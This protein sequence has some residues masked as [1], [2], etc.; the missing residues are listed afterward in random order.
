MNL[1]TTVCGRLRT[2]VRSARR[3]RSASSSFRHLFPSAGRPVGVAATIILTVLLALAAGSNL[4]MAGPQ[5]EAV[6]AL[7][8]PRQ[9]HTAT[10]LADGRVLIV[11]GQDAS[12][13]LASAEVYDP[14]TRSF[15]AAGA[16]STARTG[17]AATLLADGRVLITGGQ[18]NALTLASA[19]IFDVTTPGFQPVAGSM[20]AAR[21]GHT[22]TLLAS[23]QVLLAGGDAAGTAEWFDPANSTFSGSQPMVVRRSGHAAS[24][25]GDRFIFFTRGGTN[26]VELYDADAN[27]FEPWPKLLNEVRVGHTATSNPDDSI[28]LIGGEHV[29]TLERLDVENSVSAPSIALGAAGSVAQRLANDRVLVLGSNLSALFN[30][31][32]SSVAA[33]AGAETLMR[34]GQTTSELPATKH[35]LVAGGVDASDALVP[36][37]AIYTP[38]R[39]ETDKEDYYPDEP[40][41]VTGTGWKAGEE[42]DLYVVD[43]L[44]WVYDSTVVADMDG[45]FVADPYFVVLWQHLGVEFNL[46]ALGADSGLVA[47]HTFT[48]GD[49]TFGASGLPSG[50]SVTVQWSYTGQGNNPPTSSTTTFLAPGPSPA[51]FN[52]QQRTVTYQYPGTVSHNGTDYELI[53]SSPASGFNSGSGSV[54]TA[55]VANYRGVSTVTWNTPSDITYGTPLDGTQ[56]NATANV[57]GTWNYTPAASTVLGAGTHDLSVTFTPTDINFSTI[58]KTVQINVLKAEL[59]VTAND[60]SKT[61]N[62]DAYTGGNGVTYSGFVN[63]ETETVLG[64]S[65]TYGGASQGAIDAGTYAISPSGRSSGNYNISYVDGT[66][67]IDKADATVSVTGTTVTYDGDAHGATGTATGVNG[68]ALAGLDLGGSFA[69]VPGGTANWTFTDITGNYNDTSGSVAIVI[70]KADATIAVQGKTVTYDGQA[71]SATG[72]ATGVQ[73]ET[74]SG[75]DLGASYTN[76]PGGTADWTFTDVTGNYHNASGSVQIVIEK[77]NATITVQGATVT[78][79]GQAHGATGSASGVQGETLAGLNLGASFTNAP[80]GT[81][82]W[83]FTDVTGNYHNAVGSVGIVIQKANA[84]IAVQGTTVTYDGQAHGATGSATGVQGETLA[85]LD[86]GASYTN[87]PGGTANWTFTDVTGNYFDA[88]GSVAI[89]ITKAG[90]S[91]SV[92]GFSGVYDGAAHGATGSAIG[93]NGETLAGLDLGASFTNVPGGTANWTF[94]DVTGNY[95]DAS[96]SVAIV[97]DKADASITVLGAT[98]TYDGDAHGA[99]G[100]AIGVNGEALAGLD[101]GD[102]FTNVPGGIADWTFT[103]VTGNYNDDSGSVAIVINKADATV[104]VSGTTVTYDGAAHGASGTASGIGGV[105]L[106]AGLDLGAI[107][108][109]V[110]GGT[111]HWTFSGGTNYNDQ[112]GSVE[113]VINKADAVVSVSGTTVTYDGAAHGASGTATGVGGVDLSAGLDLG[114]TFINVP[115]GTAHWTFSGG[116]NYNDQSGSVAIIINKADATVSVSGSTVTYDGAAHGASGTASGIGGVDLSAGLNLGATFINVPGGTADWTFAGGTNYND[117]SGSVAIVIN[118]ADATVSVTGTTVTYDGAA[119][120]ASGTATGVGGVDLSAGLSLGATFINVPGGT[121]DWTFAGGTNYNDQSGSVA[122]IINK[123]NAT[124]SVTGTTVTYDGAAHGATGSATGVNGETL[125]GLDLGASFTNVPGGT[126][127]WTF[128]DVTGNYHDASGSVAITIDPK[129]ITITANNRTKAFGETVTYAGTEFTVTG[130]IGSDAVTSVTLTST[131]DAAN[132]LASGSPYPIVPSAPIFGAGLST[133]YTPVFVNGQLTITPLQFVGFFPPIGG[134]ITNGDG[135]SYNSPIRS[136]KLN[137]TVPVKFALFNSG[138]PFITGIHTLQATK[139]SN[140]TTSDPA[141]DVTPTDAATTGNQFRLT[142][143]EWHFNLNTKGLSA[144][145]WLLT[146]TLADGTTHQVWIAL[147]K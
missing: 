71:H 90:A 44:G 106:S 93:V 27:R 141:I 29:G 77:A 69:N 1:L 62:G 100:S 58:T 5:I 129:P 147:K 109:N 50:A 107:F 17:H 46:T 23:G 19:E 114:A 2:A 83:T 117:Q 130:V 131:G 12:G 128:T 59:T 32:D 101:L 10:V 98:V 43:N 20:S 35:I 86:L 7:A 66:L 68:E 63:S 11:G 38:A 127:N 81:A 95:Y 119:H 115:G 113:I 80:G 72:S 25:L 67:T 137:S 116:T 47:T 45:G 134:S 82:N 13:P 52:I 108:I 88:S 36:E 103:D 105:D 15:A 51:A 146:A 24:T 92:S 21:S 75:L 4:L 79:D 60:D 34:R 37:A 112:S 9:G 3:T 14:E 118:K 123:A 126:A 28:L 53:G 122:I 56:L 49:V 89:V 64:G 26:S 22:A 143:S 16:M 40:V 133:N 138:S 145:T 91:I 70:D 132:A 39:I 94:T 61:Y 42:V 142:G 110:P 78:Y 144:G 54:T 96:G 65:L 136:Y 48:D 6:G 97:I 121:A 111:A 73:G 99:S 31:T 8:E 125:A 124:V 84:T 85:G 76:V 41:I 57:P 74:L 55:V 140:A 33:I 120:G 102:S 139:Y 30:P 87:V 135:G 104:S 18:L